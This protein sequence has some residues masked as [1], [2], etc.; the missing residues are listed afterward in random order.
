MRN[1]LIFEIIL[2]NVVRSGG[3]IG[4]TV[5]DVE[6]ARGSV[7]RDHNVIGVCDVQIL[8]NKQIYQVQLYLIKD[9]LST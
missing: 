2:S 8:K 1:Y 6:A 9:H 4:M 7:S 3:I 5:D